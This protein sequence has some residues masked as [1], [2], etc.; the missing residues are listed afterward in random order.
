VDIVLLYKSDDDVLL[1]GQL[2]LIQVKIGKIDTGVWR[3][4]VHS[5]LMELLYNP[6]NISP[7]DSKELS[8][9]VVLITSGVINDNVKERI[10]D[11]NNRH[12]FPIEYLEGYDFAGIL[13]NYNYTVQWLLEDL[14]D[15]EYM[16]KPRKVQSGHPK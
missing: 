11:I 4:S 13:Y 6:L 5:Q 9:R 16:N 3:R 8:R 7:F 1:R 12:L 10:T 15:T 14:D 2:F